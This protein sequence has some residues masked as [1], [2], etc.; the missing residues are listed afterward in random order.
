MLLILSGLILG[1]AALAVFGAGPRP[2]P[3]R[4]CRQ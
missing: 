3:V 4:L 2:R 1:A